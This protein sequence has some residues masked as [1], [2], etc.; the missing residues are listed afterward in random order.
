M[1][2]S[3]RSILKRYKKAHNTEELQGMVKTCSHCGE[4]KQ[5]RRGRMWTPC[6]LCKKLEKGRVV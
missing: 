6:P 2:T 4:G 5:Y 3:D 1:E